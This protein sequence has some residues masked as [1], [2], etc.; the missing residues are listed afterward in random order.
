MFPMAAAAFA[1]RATQNQAMGT[2]SSSW[3]WMIIKIILV[4]GVLA[5]IGYYISKFNPFAMI[6]GIF[7]SA[8]PSRVA[9]CP[10]TYTNNGATCGRS[11]KF[12][13]ADFGLG[14]YE[15]GDCPKGYY[16]DGTSCMFKAFGRGTG[17]AKL[18]GG[19]GRCEKG[20]GLGPGG[21]ESNGAF[22]YPKCQALARKRGYANP[23]K[24]T[25]DGCCMCSPK[26]GYRSLSFS[27]HLKCPPANDK[28][29]KYTKRIKALCYIDCA[30][31]YGHKDW[32]HNG[33]QCVLNVSTK[34]IGSMTCKKGETKI[35]PRCY[36]PCPSGKK[37]DSTGLFC[38]NK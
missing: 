11:A 8:R 19:I 5:V 33:T 13:T 36:K 32:Q 30:K 16:N 6:M 24:W 37:P 38:I 34:G 17:W 25:S 28:E 14:P 22:Y 31:A 4:L 2:S 3:K 20:E 15:S 21:C 10:K 27:K 35:G 18:K 9:D 1:S 12:K 7:K 29:K 23:D 26:K